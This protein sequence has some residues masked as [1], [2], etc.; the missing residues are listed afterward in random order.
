[1]GI[2]SLEDS[3]QALQISIVP[4]EKAEFIL[5]GMT[6]RCVRDI[7]HKGV[8]PSSPS[9]F[10]REDVALPHFYGAHDPLRYVRNPYCV[11]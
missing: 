7:V 5:K 2:V 1:L 10:R 4:F 8:E 3:I 6:K 11:G 9:F